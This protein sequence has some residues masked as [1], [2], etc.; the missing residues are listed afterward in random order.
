[1]SIYW[2]KLPKVNEFT[3]DFRKIF[4]SGY[5]EVNPQEGPQTAFIS[6]MAGISGKERRDEDFPLVFYGGAK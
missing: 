2:D 4:G 5:L 3:L 1:M 6:C